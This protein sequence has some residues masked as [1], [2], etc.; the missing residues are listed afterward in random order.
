MAQS[1]K[2]MEASLHV[3][4]PTSDL[5]K[6]LKEKWDE[7]SAKQE[8]TTVTFGSNTVNNGLL[9]GNNAGQLQGNFNFGRQ[10]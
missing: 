7:C 5:T 2:A 3:L 6:E 9:I 8:T 1:T 4:R 10:Q